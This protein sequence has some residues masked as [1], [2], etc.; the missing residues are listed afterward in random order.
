MKMQSSNQIILHRSPVLKS[1]ISKIK[2][3]AVT[4]KVPSNQR[5]FRHHPEN[6]SVIQ[7][8]ANPTKKL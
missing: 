6:V 4:F 7:N 5:R 1:P 2:P 3:K 8:A